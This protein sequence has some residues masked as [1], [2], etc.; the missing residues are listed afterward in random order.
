MVVYAG[1]PSS[2]ERLHILVRLREV[3]HHLRNA[4]STIS[5]LEAFTISELVPCVVDARS[6]NVYRQRMVRGHPSKQRSGSGEHANTTPVNVTHEYT[7]AWNAR[8]GLECLTLAK[9]NC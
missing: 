9:C 3:F 4:S 5:Y 6:C 1:S 8:Q 7:K 2:F